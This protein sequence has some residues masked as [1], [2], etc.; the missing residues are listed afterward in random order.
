MSTIY[1]VGIRC[2]HMCGCNCYCNAMTHNANA[3]F[4]L[5]CLFMV[6]KASPAIEPVLEQRLAVC[7]LLSLSTH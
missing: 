1:V 7:S 2:P 4:V 6:G 3:S 5:I